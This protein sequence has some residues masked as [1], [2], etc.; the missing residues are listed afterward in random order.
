MS[1]SELYDTGYGPGEPGMA[2]ANPP[3]LPG[4]PPS[5]GGLDW[6]QIL[7]QMAQGP[8]T[9]QPPQK[10]S[11]VE[12][13]MTYISPLVSAWAE[14]RQILNWKR[15]RNAFLG[16][17]GAGGLQTALTQIAAPRLQREALAEKQRAANQQWFEN[18]TKGAQ[19][20]A[21]IQRARNVTPPETYQALLTRR[22]AAGDPQAEQ[23]L[24]KLTAKEPAPHYEQ[25]ALGN[26]MAMV[27]A[28]ATPV[29]TR[30]PETQELP[31]PVGMVP[32]FEAVTVP[33]GEWQQQPVK[34][35]QKPTAAR[36]A[37]GS[38]RSQVFNL[39]FNRALKAGQ[40]E[41]DAQSAGVD[42]VAE[43]SN[44]M[45]KPT[46][47]SAPKG[48]NPAKFDALRA[49]QYQQYKSFEDDFNNP[50]NSAY[51]DVERLGQRKSEL[52]A[53]FNDRQKTLQGTAGQGGAGGGGKSYVPGHNPG[54]TKNLDAATS[55]QIFTEAGGD[56]A[57]AERIARQRGYKF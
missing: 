45:R 39:A 15:R 47:V 12:K 6:E 22:A 26:Y 33:T 50:M 19:V 7:G 42:A 18:L 23:E 24:Q 34:A 46:K 25:D 21:E 16:L 55:T 40:A 4:R 57:V 36:N 43:I 11:S 5:L 3:A 32:G 31:L 48:V 8:P 51:G 27:G 54:G 49:W 9:V 52:D 17:L 56:P 44:A 35:F 41:E 30:T 20:G 38:L 53:A 1:V 14:S 28:Q 10:P 37:S 2:G 13:V 29:T